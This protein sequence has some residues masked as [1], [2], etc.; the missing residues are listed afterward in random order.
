MTD[1]TSTLAVGFRCKSSVYH[2]LPSDEEENAPIEGLF[3]WTSL[4]PQLEGSRGEL[5]C[6]TLGLPVSLRYKKNVLRMQ[7]QC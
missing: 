1:P 7:Q 2:S 4:V 5:L 6:T 3:I